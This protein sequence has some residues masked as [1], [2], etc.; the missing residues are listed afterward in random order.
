MSGLFRPE[1]LQHQQH[2]LEGEVTIATHMSFTII[3]AVIIGIVVI[4]IAFLLWGEY[5]RKEVVS[6]YLRP[7]SGLSK[8]FAPAAG[9][10]DE[11]FVAEGEV[12]RKGQR[13]ARVR[14]DRHLSSG[15]GV[16]DA[17]IQELHTQK[18][19]LNSQRTAHQSLLQLNTRNLNSQLKAAQ[20]QQQQNNRQLALIDERIALSTKRLL[21]AQALVAKGFASQQEGSSQQDELLTLQQQREEIHT[22]GLTYQDR[23]EQLH[24]Q[25]QQL[26]VEHEEKQLGLDA[27]LAE[28]NQSLA[29]A[30]GQRSFDVISHRDGVVTNLQA[31]AGAMANA[32]QP[33]MTVLPENAALEAVLFVP[34]RAYGFVA[35]GQLTRIR[36]QAFPYQRFG[37]YEGTISGVSKSVLLPNEATLPVAYNE[38][39]YQVV[40]SLGQQGASA[41]GVD[42][43]LQAGMLLEADILID[44]RTLFEWLLEPLFSVRGGM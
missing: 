3:L 44:S 6:G 10:V 27:Q 43:P 30:D 34:T 33:L 41:Y 14:V 18:Q 12:V 16:N 2:K 22:A 37:I 4:A 32:S 21:D 19:L 26:P 29:Q 1:A 38:P 11:V 5:H 25:L 13:L 36:Y 7:T 9:I 35:E 39:V 28:L 24:V 31:V 40:V 15:S 42:V 8:V 17:I 23:I 20:A